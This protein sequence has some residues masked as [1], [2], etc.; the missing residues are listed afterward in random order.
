MLPSVFPERLREG[1]E[2]DCLLSCVCPCVLCSTLYV[3][4]RMWPLPALLCPLCDFLR[5]VSSP[6]LSAVSELL[7]HGLPQI[8]SRGPESLAL[9]SDRQYVEE[10]ARQRQYCILLL[11]YL[12]YIHE[13]RSVLRAGDWQLVLEATSVARFSSITIYRGIL[14]RSGA[15]HRGNGDKWEMACIPEGLTVWR[16]R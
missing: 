14:S 13:D 5:P 4:T 9:L 2:A 15:E 12:A 1:E 10:A 7:Q 3:Q 6:E 16:D 8:S 11:F